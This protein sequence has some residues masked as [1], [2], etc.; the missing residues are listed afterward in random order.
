[1]MH[2]SC[3]KHIIQEIRGDEEFE[4]GSENGRKSCQIKACK[5]IQDVFNAL[6]ETTFWCSDVGLTRIEEC[7][8]FVHKS[9]SLVHIAP[10]YYSTRTESSVLPCNVPPIKTLIFWWAAEACWLFVLQACSLKPRTSCPGPARVQK[11]PNCYWKGCLEWIVT[12]L[13]F[14][15]FNLCICL[16]DEWNIILV[17]VA[18]V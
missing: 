14:T 1:M 7:L 2:I 18:Y 17:I 4:N 15:C 16:S 5:L 3:W 11:L 6:T 9:F 10:W 13:N 8:C 12:R